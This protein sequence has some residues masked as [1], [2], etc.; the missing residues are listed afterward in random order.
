[1]KD[2]LF[3]P[4]IK[5]QCKKDECVMWKHETCL[6]TVFFI[7]NIISSN[8]DNS[9]K[10][11]DTNTEL[12][13]ELFS[14]FAVALDSSDEQD[15]PNEILDSIFS[16]SAAELADEIIQFA[17]DEDL[18]DDDESYL[19]HEI[20]DLFWSNKGLELSNKELPQKYRSIKKKAWL[21]AS[22]KVKKESKPSRQSFFD[23]DI[24]ND[25]KA[26]SS[27]SND[28]LVEQ[29]LAFAKES[30]LGDDD[31]EPLSR[32]TLEIFW[33]SKGIQNTYSISANASI[34]IKQVEKLARDKINARIFSASNDEL[35]QE[36]ADYAKKKAGKDNGQGVYVRAHSHT[37]WRFKGLDYRTDSLEIEQRKDEIE[38]LAQEIIDKDFHEWRDERL[39]KESQYLP[40]LVQA[41]VEWAR[42][43]GRTSV[44]V[45]DVK[46]FRQ[47][48]KLDI[49][50]ATE[51]ALYL[52][53]NNELKTRKKAS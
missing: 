6:V 39:Q 16:K 12:V 41:C 2:N 27:L 21:I 1:M 49:L 15:T 30:K 18:L 4:L 40:Q 14:G 52:S 46:Y 11:S 31:L 24:D 8:M 51:R 9:G 37:F 5:E 26:I 29:L 35:S 38:Q 42:S 44:T 43:T 28:L 53:A 48:K 17:K 22:T 50:E 19:S 23:R 34:K 32:D 3:C 20:E 10:M 7:S 47:E 33:K 36:L 45:N 25:E 13:E